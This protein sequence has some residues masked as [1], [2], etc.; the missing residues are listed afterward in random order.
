VIEVI[1]PFAKNFPLYLVSPANL[2]ELN[3]LLP[4]PLLKLDGYGNIRNVQLAAPYLAGASAVVGI[5]DDEVVEI[6]DYLTKVTKHIG[7]RVNGETVGGMAGP[8]FDRKGDYRLGDAET[9]A[10][11][12]NIFLKKNYYMNEALKKAM[13][14]A[15]TEI[16]KNNVAFGG[17]MVMSRETIARICHDP[18]IPRGEDY[19]YVINAAMDG[20]SFFFQPGMWVT[21]LPPDSTGSQAGDKASKLV[22]DIRRFIYMREKTRVYRELFP[23]GP[24]DFCYLMPYPGVYLDASI[25]LTLH[26]VR[27]LDE[28]YPDYRKSHS[29][30]KLVEDAV[31]VAS[32]KAREFFAYQDKWRA[33]L[34]AA[35]RSPRSADVVNGFAVNG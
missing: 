11:H 14:P 26:G 1:K 24:L 23:E 30:E 3:N 32:R 22:A 17:N 27:A 33:A 18:Y 5:D 2:G 8:Y 12:P 25:D 7:S 4:E 35:S 21:H 10:R 34:A 13:A 19:D 9:L 16:V 6:P 31:S 15:A 29:P 28:K 20:I